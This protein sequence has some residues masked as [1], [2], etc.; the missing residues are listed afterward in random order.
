MMSLE[1]IEFR[2]KSFH[3]LE[4]YRQLSAHDWQSD[5]YNCCKCTSYGGRVTEHL[6]NC[7]TLGSYVMSDYLSELL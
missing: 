2:R 4:I 7:R 5:G 3:C 6:N 1:D